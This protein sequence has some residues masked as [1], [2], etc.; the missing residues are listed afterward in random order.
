MSRMLAVDP[1]LR[2]TAKSA[3]THPFLAG[4]NVRDWEPTTDAERMAR[5]VRRGAS[6]GAR[7]N[8][9]ARNTR[10]LLR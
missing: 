2:I 6:E 3:L 9:N 4:G 8:A 10:L 7:A 1:F 5:K